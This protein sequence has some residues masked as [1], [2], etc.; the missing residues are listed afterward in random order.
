MNFWKYL[1][2][3]I[4]LCIV[5][6]LIYRLVFVLRTGTDLE[7]IRHINCSCKGTAPEPATN[8]AKTE[9]L[10]AAI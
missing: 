9:D 7:T 6:G 5:G 10:L 3:L 2:A 4:L 8:P 1:G